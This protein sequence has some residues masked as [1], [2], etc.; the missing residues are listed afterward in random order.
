[1]S[2]TEGYVSEVNYTSGF[3]GE[4]SPLKLGLATLIK[5]IQPPDSSQEFTYCELPVVRVLPRIF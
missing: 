3:Y 2:W 5:S 4:L 1:M